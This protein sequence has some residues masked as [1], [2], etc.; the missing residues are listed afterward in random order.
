MP[1]HTPNSN[2]KKIW[3]ATASLALSAALL[4]IATACATT[5]PDG[6]LT[7]SGRRAIR[8]GRFL[9]KIG[10]AKPVILEDAHLANL[11]NPESPGKTESPGSP[12][13]ESESAP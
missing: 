4:A 11:P 3:T 2:S 6:N 5:T 12:G 9:Q 1:S 8:R 13:K 7:R 10:L